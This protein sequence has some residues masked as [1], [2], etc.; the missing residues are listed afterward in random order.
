MK[1]TIIGSGPTGLTLAYILSL[2]NFN[3]E[4]IEQHE[5]LGGS[6]N[7]QWIRDDYFSENSPRVFSNSGNSK[8]LLSH[9]GF[10][11]KDFQNIYGNFF[12]TN[13]K[14]V[15]FVFKHFNLFDY[16]IFLFAAIKYK[17][18]LENKT[19]NDWIT[20]S[21]LSVS[22]KKAIKIIS[23]L[24]CDRP[25]KTNIN[26]FFGSI[27]Y[28]LPTQ[29]R[30]PN[31]WH[32]IIE[33]H[34]ISKNVNILKNT[35]VINLNK[36]DK[37][38]YLHTKNTQAGYETII[39]SNKVFLCTQS[40]GIYSIIKNTIFENNWMHIN[41]M[42]KWS[43]NTFYSGFGFQLHFNKIVKFKNEWCWSCND[44]WTVIILPVSN[45]LKKYSNDSEIKTVWSC[46]I[47][48]M[49]TKSKRLNKTANECNLNEVLNECLYQIR[50]SYK[51]PEPKVI[52][53]SK[54][55]KKI[56]NKWKSRNTGYTKNIYDDLDMKG[57]EDNLY[58]L[59]CFTKM[60][61]NHISY[62]VG[63]IDAVAEYLKKYENL[64]NNIFI[65]KW[66][67]N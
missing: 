65:S 67:I 50:N 31:K 64:D 54:G 24:I 6:W 29:M 44:D 47:V 30:E 42:K 14:I 36:I 11:N 52:T 35:K 25:D 4:L 38:F 3:I 37:T 9:L 23:I 33:N 17:F 58:A 45:W 21:N 59:G 57:R 63:A 39:S 46:C 32:E 1:Y 62:M 16:I 18:I 7:S 48:D 27:S 12:Q 41:K 43:E 40:D 2:N 53:I 10:T 34:L 55:L 26:D 49:D 20:Q 28:T 51:I 8:I 66:K 15:S 60:K 19:L 13:F 61:K 56:N 22:A 5:Q